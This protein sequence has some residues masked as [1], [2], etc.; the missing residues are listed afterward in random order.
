VMALVVDGAEVEEAGQGSEV[1]VV[2]NQTPFYGE[3]GGQVGDQGTIEGAGGKTRVIVTDTQKRLGDLHVHLGRVAAGRLAV[4]AEVRLA[5]DGARRARLRANHS[6][7]HLLHE[8]LRRTLGPHVTQKGSLVAPDRLRFDFSHPRAMS[9]DEIDRVEAEVNRLVLANSEVGTRLMRPDDAVAAGALALFGE[10]YGEE[11]RVVAMGDGGDGRRAYSVEL[12]GGTHV[13]RTGDIGLFKIVGESGVAAGVR[14]LEALTGEAARLHLLGQERRLAQA[15]AL[16]R[17]APAE[18]PD[19][20][21]GLLEERRRFEKEL[22]ETRRRLSLGGAVG[23][24]DGAQVRE[25]AGVKL[26]AQQL[27]GVPARELKGM[28]DDWKKRLG[29]GVVALVAVA[30]GKAAL[31][32]GVTEDLT[33]R[34]DARAL[35]KAGAAELGGKGGGGRADMAQSGGPDVGRAQAALAAVEHALAKAAAPAG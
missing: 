35:V 20:V 22:A 30:E 6:A 28:V 27:D 15:A 10:K 3:S 34:Y 26:A 14:R 9:E 5:I 16:L 11:V 24:A 25:V 19:R 4:G 21:A 12:C 18:V 23:D 33:D 13:R 31:V 7:T 1:A 17:A 2:L 29:S 8:A 32:V